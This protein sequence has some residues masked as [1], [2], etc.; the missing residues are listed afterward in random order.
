MNRISL[1]IASILTVVWLA[2]GSFYTYGQS[3][4][5]LTKKEAKEW[6]REGDWLRDRDRLTPHKSINQMELADQYNRHKER[7]DKAFAYLQRTDLASIEPGRY[8]IDGDDVFVTVSNVPTKEFKNTKYESHKV[9]ADIHYVFE[10][11]E[12]L[13]IAP[14]A[15]AAVI[16]EYDPAKEIMFHE[17]KGK[18]YVEDPGTFF[19]VF[20]NM[21]A[22]RPGIRVEGF[23]QVKKIVIKIR[24]DD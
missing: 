6:F 1:K 15:G 24:A 5:A 7:W 22:H 17:A 16:E 13:G 18:Y 20:P 3:I 10:G 21:D 4:N 19:I 14:V 23:D 8:P 11:K 2:V 9:Y 12:K